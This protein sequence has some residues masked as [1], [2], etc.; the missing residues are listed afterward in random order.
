MYFAEMSGYINEN[1]IISEIFSS[2]FHTPGFNWECSPAQTELENILMDWIAEVLNLPTKFLIKNEGGGTLS[3]ST[4]HS[5][6]HSINVAK[7]KKMEE[8]NIIFSDPQ[9]MKFVAYFP[10]INSKK[11]LKALKLKEVQLYRKIPM[12]F[13]EKQL[14]YHISY[15]ILEESIKQD[16]ANGLIPFWCDSSLG[17]EG[18]C[19]IDDLEL[20]S[21][22]CEKYHISLSVNANW[23][24]WF[25]M[26]PEFREMYIKALEKADFVFVNGR[27]MFGGG[28]SSFMYFSSKTLFRK[29]VGGLM[30][31]PMVDVSLKVKNLM[32]MKDFNIGFGKRFNSYKFYFIIRRLG[33]EGIRRYLIRK[34]N[35]GDYFEKLLKTMDSFKILQRNVFGVICFSLKEQNLNG[36][37]LELVN[38][39]SSTGMIGSIQIEEEMILR[40]SINN[41]NTEE[42]HLNRIFEKIKENTLKVIK[43]K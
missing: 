12:V 1:T 38:K 39:E 19:N 31:Y 27:Y 34:V 25:M 5:Y 40:V 43:L 11:A 42:V 18:L 8:L 41:E 16:I 30:G 17:S 23:G 33:I 32:H 37:L 14:N 13:D 6:F 2:A 35:L 36:I 24:G 22:I 20:I 4:T 7:Y 9:T 29:S 28:L 10:A 3:T 21:A 15:E 26:L